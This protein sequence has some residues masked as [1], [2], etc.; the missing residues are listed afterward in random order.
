MK[1]KP[2]NSLI[3]SK[4]NTTA[5]QEVIEKLPAVIPNHFKIGEAVSKGDCFFDAF[6]QGLNQL[7][8]SSLQTVKSLR[9]LCYQYV[10][11]TKYASIREKILKDEHN[12]DSFN[13]YL[14][15][16]PF[17][18][19]EIEEME[20]QKLLTG[21]ATWG[22]PDLEGRIICEH[23]NLRLHVIEIH[24]E[25]IDNQLQVTECLVDS[26]GSHQIEEM[27]GKDY[28]QA[29]IIHIINYKNHFFPLLDSLKI[30]NENV[31]SS[32]WDTLRQNPGKT[33][34]TAGV[35]FS[36]GFFAFKYSKNVNGESVPNSIASTLGL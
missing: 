23:F 26:Q 31:F 19:S 24:D 7:G 14:M 6:A 30:R 16:L 29:D 36:L 22:R 8:L 12:E 25:A 10:K 9:L 4:K 11:N 1:E 20:N 3:E 13:I 15:R 21:S 5:N 2:D 32:C 18:S 17:T 35:A 33:L 27:N 28:L 34:L